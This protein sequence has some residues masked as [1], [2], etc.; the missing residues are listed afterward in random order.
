MPAPSSTSTVMRQKIFLCLAGTAAF[1]PGVWR[2]FPQP[3][4]QPAGFLSDIACGLAIFTLAIAS[5]RWL[6]LPLLILWTMFQVCAQELLAAMQR[7]PNWRDLHYLAN[8]DFVGASTEGL[9]FSSPYLTAMLFATALAAGLWPARFMPGKRRLLVAAIILLALHYPL[10]RQFGEQSVAA[11]YNPLHWLMASAWS[12]DGDEEKVAMP[13]GLVG[14]DLT[15]K[16]ILAEKKAKNLLIIA[17]EGIPGIYHP[18]IRA[19]IPAPPAEISMDKLAAAT[20]DAMLIPDFVA[21]SH[22]TIRGQY[23]ML[24]GDFSKQSW[25]TPKA[26]ELQNNRER[27]R[28]CLPARLA[29]AG[30][31]THYLQGADLN[32]MGKDWVMPMLGFQRVH[33]KEWFKEKN[34]FPFQWGAVDEVFF[35]GAASY[36]AELQAKSQAS[37]QP[38][39]LMLFTVGTHQPYAVP[40]SLVARYPNRKLASV[41]LLDKAVADF[42]KTLR[43]RGVLDNTL[44]LVTSDESHGSELA[45]WISSWGLGIVLAPGD[46]PPRLKEGGY[47]LLDVEASVLDYFDLPMPPAIIGRSFFRD[48]EKPR[49]MVSFTVSRRRW[50]DAAGIRHECSE[51]RL[52]RQVKAT[53]ILGTPGEFQDDEAGEKLFAIGAQLDRNLTAAKPGERTMQFAQGELRRLPAKVKNDWAD[54]LAGAQYLDFPAGSE[55]KVAVRV[56]AM[57]APPRGIQLRL[58]AKEWEY[59]QLDIPIPAFPLLKTGESCLVEFSFKNPEAR[60]SFS[61]YL[62]GE[63]KNAL[64]RIDEFAVTVTDP[65]QSS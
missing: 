36:I 60:Q 18:E 41:A 43:K 9:H 42:I 8:P 16:P 24:C 39:M 46:K 32:F 62:L 4:W 50:H 11:R 47:G 14:L 29:A 1:L 23:A 12:L 57:K 27:A 64:I 65:G 56:Q 6:R 26:Y 21:H 10:C 30:F 55:V 38:W 7:F 58:L 61:F 25:D 44:V 17:L 33:G 63:G 54:N 31:T 34:P 37:D 35:R 5:P 20:P 51:D 59:D 2:L 3:T 15:G 49:E 45:D 48:Y 22:Q 13:P 19:A 40:D 28:Q 52:C 53:S